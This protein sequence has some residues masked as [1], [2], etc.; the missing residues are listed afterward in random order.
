MGLQSALAYCIMGWL[1]P[2]LQSRG[3]DGVTA[4]LVVSVSIMLQVVASLVVPPL[5]VRCNDQ[6][7][8]NIGLAAIAGLA[9]LGLLFAPPSTLWVW[10]CLQGRRSEERRV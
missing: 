2:I 6:R 10:A 5:A 4:G 3:V 9:L 1:A 7:L 8:I